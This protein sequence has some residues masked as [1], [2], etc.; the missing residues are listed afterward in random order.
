MGKKKAITRL[1]NTPSSQPSSPTPLDIS[2]V[3][4]FERQDTLHEM[5]GNTN[6]MVRIDALNSITTLLKSYNVT[7]I[8]HNNLYHTIVGL[9][10]DKMINVG[11]AA[12]ALLRHVV[13]ICDVSLLN[14]FIA[15]DLQSVCYQLLQNLYPLYQSFTQSVVITKGHALYWYNPNYLNMIRMLNHIVKILAALFEVNDQITTKFVNLLISQK[16]FDNN[17]QNV[18]FLSFFFRLLSQKLSTIPPSIIPTIHLPFITQLQLDILHCLR[19]ISHEN[20]TV[21]HLFLENQAIMSYFLQEPTLLLQT[22]PQTTTT[23]SYSPPPVQSQPN[24]PTDM[25]IIVP[26]QIIEAK[27]ESILN[28]QYASSIVMS[29]LGT[30][31]QKVLSNSKKNSALATTFTVH[32]LPHSNIEI[33]MAI[34]II[35]ANMIEQINVQ[36]ENFINNDLQSTTLQSIYTTMFNT[37]KFAIENIDLN[38]ETAIYTQ[39]LSTIRNSLVS[40]SNGDLS[41]L[42]QYTLQG[43]MSEYTNPNIAVQQ[44]QIQSRTRFKA[45]NINNFSDAQQQQALLVESLQNLSTQRDG[46]GD[47]ASNELDNVSAHAEHENVQ[48]GDVDDMMGN[49]GVSGA[50]QNEGFTEDEFPLHQLWSDAVYIHNN[51][52]TQ[53]FNIK[54]LVGDCFTMLLGNYVEGTGDDGEDDG[55]VGNDDAKNVAKNSKQNQITNQLT[56]FYTTLP[57]LLQPNLIT[58]LLNHSYTHIHQIQSLFNISSYYPSSLIFTLHNLYNA[59]PADYPTYISS[60]SYQNTLLRITSLTNVLYLI[61]YCQ[62]FKIN[63]FSTQFFYQILITIASSTSLA[64]TT[65]SKQTSLYTLQEHFNALSSL[66]ISEEV[67]KNNAQVGL[68]KISNIL[69]STTI[70]EA[71]LILQNLTT[72]INNDNLIS[73]NKKLWSNGVLKPFEQPF[74]PLKSPVMC[75]EQLTDANITGQILPNLQSTPSNHHILYI[76]DQFKIP[77]ANFLGYIV[78]AQQKTQSHTASFLPAQAKTYFSQSMHVEFQFYCIEFISVMGINY[79]LFGPLMPMLCTYFIS[80]ITLFN[81]LKQHQFNC[82]LLFQFVNLIIDLFSEDDRLVMTYNGNKMT[83][84]LNS[85]NKTY[86]DYLL[87]LKQLKLALKPKIGSKIPAALAKRQK[88]PSPTQKSTTTPT[89]SLTPQKQQ[90]LIEIQEALEVTTEASSNLAGFIQYKRG[91][92]L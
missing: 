22:Q 3:P 58:S 66:E 65:Q 57:Q 41:V 10:S 18:N 72:F 42:D 53:Y 70:D 61:Q 49:I 16:N 20:I 29:N 81:S 45:L 60:L 5:L 68:A 39:S 87:T 17:G 7:S 77:I 25:N 26:S 11:L 54:T 62:Q 6:H 28:Y 31:Y 80:L 30:E 48:N 59:E 69:N 21:T 73:E 67:S 75:T 24:F 33:A 35:L 52:I 27:S 13:Q 36:N 40:I 55:E 83:T 89:T 92:K 56:L 82:H 91:L 4:L 2:N 78:T 1:G 8:T 63:H 44:Q 84:I 79:P 50:E 12:T 85:F 76:P 23:I 15:H 88:V 71:L 90:Q 47:V 32:S 34:V 43:A 38:Q 37:M 9:M 74:P 86:G 64:Q 46:S 51:I 19:V 14:F